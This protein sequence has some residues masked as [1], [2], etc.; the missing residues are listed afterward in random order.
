MENFTWGMVKS[1]VLA[2]HVVEIT[3]ITMCSG[4]CRTV[5][6]SGGAGVN[7]PPKNAHLPPPQIF[8]E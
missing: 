4:V 2:F 6:N 8:V 5:V 7:P 3:G 1:P